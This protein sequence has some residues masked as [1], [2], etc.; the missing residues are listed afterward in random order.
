M[1]FKV[2]SLTD[3]TPEVTPVCGPRD[4]PHFEL[5]QFVLDEDTDEVLVLADVIPVVLLRVPAILPRC[6][7]QGQTDG[8]LDV[9]PGRPALQVVP[10][11]LSRRWDV[12]REIT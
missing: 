9:G 2:H 11:R 1:P 3:F 6:Q 7:R 5:A 12:L 4:E 8:A 10:R